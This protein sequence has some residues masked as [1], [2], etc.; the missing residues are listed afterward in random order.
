MGVTERP[1]EVV[2]ERKQ[3]NVDDAPTILEVRDVAKTFRVPE[4][5]IDTFKERARPPVLA[6]ELP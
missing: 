6:A 4:H 5:R 3:R 1:Y 2:G